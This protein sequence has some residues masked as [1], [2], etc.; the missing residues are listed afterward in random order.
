MD[1]WVLCQFGIVCGR[2]ERISYLG[3]LPAGVHVRNEGDACIFPWDRLSPAISLWAQWEFNRVTDIL[4]VQA[5]LQGHDP[6]GHRCILG[7]HG[8]L[9]KVAGDTRWLLGDLEKLLEDYWWLLGG[10]WEVAGG[11]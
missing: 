10:Y 11:D 8:K 5:V 4:A 7:T 9:L 6:L 1:T 2:W 3:S